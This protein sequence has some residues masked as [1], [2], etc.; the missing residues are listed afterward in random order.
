MTQR[1]EKTIGCELDVVWKLS[2]AASLISANIPYGRVEQI[3]GI[4]GVAKG[5]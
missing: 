4:P 2:L 1:I 3:R 5:L